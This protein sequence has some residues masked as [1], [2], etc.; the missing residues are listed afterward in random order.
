MEE[1]S[2]LLWA[3]DASGMRHVEEGM[4]NGIVAHSVVA[5]R[6]C[7]EAELEADVEAVKL[8][9]GAGIDGAGLVDFFDRLDANAGKLED[10]LA[11]IGTHPA[12]EERAD[13]VRNNDAVDGPALTDAQWQ[14]LKSICGDDDD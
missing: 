13:Y 12:T 14:A 11:V 4:G 7:G 6:Q 3:G 10:V 2:G 8:L 5:I 9:N 1:V